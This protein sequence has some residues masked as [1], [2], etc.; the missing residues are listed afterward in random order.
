M[1]PFAMDKSF[2]IQIPDFMKL[3]QDELKIFR[4]IF[5]ID[6]DFQSTKSDST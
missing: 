1:V 5:R 6:L 2:L 3:A 4:S